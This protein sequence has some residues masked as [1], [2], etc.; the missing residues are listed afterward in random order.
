MADKTC[1]FIGDQAS[2]SDNLDLLQ[3]RL[4][5]EVKQAVKDGFTTFLVGVDGGL[6]SLFAH[7]I[8]EQKPFHSD[9]FLE[10]AVPNNQAFKLSG[11]SEAFLKCYDGF[12]F[13]QRDFNEESIMNSDRYM[14]NMSDR[15]IIVFH[16]IEAGRSAFAMKHAHI[17]G[18]EIREIRI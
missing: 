9:L 7:L 10:A 12:R 6:D 18:K 5:E 2:F 14:L 17:T 8:I 15:V 11:M 13:Q 3:K 1:C 4:N 16:G